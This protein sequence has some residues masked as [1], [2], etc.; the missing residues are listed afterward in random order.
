MRRLVIGT[1]LAGVI[2]ALAQAPV[3]SAEEPI[4]VW[5]AGGG[6]SRKA[7]EE[8]CLDKFTKDTG[9]KVVYVEGTADL[10]QIAAQ[11]KAG[12][13]QFDTAKL[14]SSEI[15]DAIKAGYLEKLDWSV[16]DK[17][18]LTPNQYNHRWGEYA[19][20]FDVFGWALFYN[21]E[22]W[23]TEAERPKSWAD[24][25]DTKK[26][27]GP[28]GMDARARTNGNFEAASRAMG[29]PPDKVFPMDLDKVFKKLDE[30]KPAVTF[31]YEQ[32]AVQTQAMLRKEVDLI[33]AWIGRGY[34]AVVQGAPYAIVPETHIRDLGSMMVIPKGAKH[35]VNASKVIG[36]CGTA[37]AQGHYASKAYYGGSNLDSYK[38]VDPKVRTII[39]TAP[40]Y[41]DTTVVIDPEWYGP[42]LNEIRARWNEWR[43]R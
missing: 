7:H 19:V 8:A 32:G 30:I 2:A 4:V 1:T 9:I 37:E 12:T 22:K 21:T 13:P 42:R 43:T 31:W 20:T 18:K 17:S 16:I 6:V 15:D 35:P 14:P 10:G 3:W 36:A 38:F 11:V 25:W 28:R 41:K 23:K 33:S 39:S 26:F 29:T 34:D 40:E 24:F 5:V 27:P